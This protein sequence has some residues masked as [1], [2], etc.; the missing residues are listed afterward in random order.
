MWPAPHG[1]FVGSAG[2]WTY[3]PLA[4]GTET[5][6]RCPQTGIGS[7]G[8]ECADEKSLYCVEPTRL[9]VLDVASAAVPST[10]SLPFAADAK[11][12]SCG[13]DGEWLYVAHADGAHNS[14]SRLP[15]RGGARTRVPR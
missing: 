5:Q 6:L 1:V 9:T 2:E 13:V 15:K 3:L 11:L 10:S 8:V 7:R 14:V 4:G 12:H